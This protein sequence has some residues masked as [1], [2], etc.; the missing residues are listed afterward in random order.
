MKVTHQQGDPRELKLLDENARYM[1]F[2]TFQLL[3]KTIKEDGALQQWPFVWRN[4]D[5]DRIVLSGNHRVKAAITAGL[6]EIDWTECD[7]P[8]TRDE[9]IR[10][11]LA[12]NSI[13]GE[14]DPTI[15]RK[16]YESIEN[17]DEKILTG[18]DD[19][20]LDLL[21]KTTTEAL[22]EANLNYTSLMVMFLPPEY[23]RAVAAM[24]EAGKLADRTWLAKRD[25]HSRMLD[26]IEDARESAHVMNTAT[27]FGLLLDVWD[28]HREDLRENW[29]DDDGVLLGS[30]KD[31]VPVTSLFG[32][33]M[34]VEVGQLVAKKLDDLA[35]RG[36]IEKPW[37]AL[38]TWAVSDD[39]AS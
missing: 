23:E 10:I 21:T 15:L 19:V 30:A 37:E 18:L 17:V 22:A 11:Q 13:S 39:D 8:L 3:V 25:Q 20:E 6:T 24:D 27:A 38:K 33:T 2:E 1:P 35:K 4:P 31:D 7:E 28:K 9:R 29:L 36:K 16:L 34:P 5:G 26:A 32:M 14:D 12:H